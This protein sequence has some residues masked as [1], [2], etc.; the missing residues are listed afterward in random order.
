MQEAWLAVCGM[1]MQVTYSKVS[2]NLSHQT[3]LAS[4]HDGITDRFDMTVI[5]SF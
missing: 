3:V 4:A 2:N 5:R 1:E